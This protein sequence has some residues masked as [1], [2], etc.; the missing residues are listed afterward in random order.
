[1][2][3][4]IKNY[5]DISNKN[6]MNFGMTFVRG[7]DIPLDLSC[8]F[9]SLADAEKYAK[10]EDDERMLSSIAYVGQVLSVKTGVDSNGKSIYKL[11]TIQGDN[12]LK[13]VDSDITLKVESGV[14]KYSEDGK[15]WKTLEA[16]QGA[17]GVTGPTGPQGPTG[18]T[19]PKGEPGK[20]GVTGVTGP[21]GDKG[22]QG[23]KG[24][25]GKDGSTGPQGPKGDPGA[26]GATGP[27][28]P[29][30]P[31]GPQGPTGK[32]GV[33][34]I[35][36]KDGA[37]GAT[38]PKGDTGATG[39]TGATGPKGDTGATGATG[40]T[41]PQGPKGDPGDV[42]GI[43]YTP[44]SDTA[45]TI[46]LG[47][48][49]AGT[50][51]SALKGKSMSAMFDELLFPTYVPKYTDAI[52]SAKLSSVI[53]LVE[54]GTE[55]PTCTVS[56][57]SCSAQVGSK[58]FVGGVGTTSIEFSPNDLNT[59]GIKTWSYKAS[60]LAGTDIVV[61]NKGNNCP[62][63]SSNETTLRSTCD[64]NPKTYNT[65]TEDKDGDGRYVLASTI[66]TG[67]ISLTVVYPYFKPVSDTE[68]TMVALT[69]ANNFVVNNFSAMNLGT[70][71]GIKL[72][73]TFTNV[74][75]TPK[76]TSG[77]F[78]TSDAKMV[79]NGELTLVKTTNETINGQT[80][81]YTE[82]RMTDS[83][84]PGLNDYK[85]QFTKA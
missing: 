25:P 51:G 53:N 76:N 63:V 9:T 26:T 36:G 35:D 52:V 27:T 68:F 47:G 16:G 82:Y 71:M 13:Q 55:L 7:N 49:G 77:T 15:T 3:T 30:G 22:E 39:Q 34:G 67:T 85:I 73:S 72:P 83:N 4:D 64:A 28:G 50:L 70:K 40:P 38:G 58:T 59:V 31:Q 65:H 61:D 6:K 2:A 18:A 74:S 12:S 5:T 84:L 11:Y 46:A 14:L 44:Y 80:V 48:I 24:E 41:G 1:M 10:G 69:N 66:K 54:I 17:Q 75:I 60:F 29:T 45:Q 21:K 43:S 78:A 19:G 42:S 20:D 8:W 32:D 37:T 62:Y 56:C 33:D 57:K 81:S 79:T 23:P